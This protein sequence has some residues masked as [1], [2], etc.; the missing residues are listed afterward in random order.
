MGHFSSSY[1][2]ERSCCCH[3]ETTI[4]KHPKLESLGVRCNALWAK[5]DDGRSHICHVK[6][7]GGEVDIGCVK[8]NIHALKLLRQMVAQAIR[9]ERENAKRIV[10]EMDEQKKREKPKLRKLKKAHA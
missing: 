10:E 9:A 1:T 2:T 8:T 6:V 3:R 5:F 4:I 7:C